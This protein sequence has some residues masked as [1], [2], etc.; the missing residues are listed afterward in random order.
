MKKKKLDPRP[1]GMS[2]MV[3]YLTVADA[4]KAADFYQ[5]AFGFEV[6]EKAPDTK[7]KIQHAE[8]RYKDM[9]IMCGSEGAWNS[10][11]Q[12]PAH[13]SFLSPVNLYLYCE[14]VDALY[15]HLK[16]IKAELRSGVEDTFWGDRMLMVGDP[17]GHA[18]IFATHRAP[19]PVEL[20][21]RKRR[22]TSEIKSR[23]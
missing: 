8:L 20:P 4:G 22:S 7:G 2:W 17:D 1:K 16:S 18:W 15:D 21:K 10:P 3:P 6:V 11:V 23:R 12:T 9:V 5:E 13:G 19:K 14:D